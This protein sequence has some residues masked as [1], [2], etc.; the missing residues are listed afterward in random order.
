MRVTA[1]IAAV[2]ALVA[3]ACTDP[4]E[5]AGTSESSTTPGTGVGL[6]CWSAEPQDG[7][8]GIRFSDVTETAGLIEPLLGMKGHAAA[9]GDVNG[10]LILDLVV[11]TF[12]NARGDVYLERG[13]TGPAPDRLLLGDGGSFSVD[14][15][16]P[17]GIGRTSGAVIV[18]LDND[19][20]DDLVLSRNVVDDQPGDATTVFEQTPDGWV[21]VDA[22]IDPA[23]AGR[24][25]GVLDADGDG[26]LDLLIVVDRYRDG[27]SRIYRNIGGLEFQDMTEDWGLG[28]GV[29]GLG[30][31]TGDV[32]G[33]RLTDVFIAGSNR[34]FIGTGHGLEEVD[35]GIGPWETIGAE[36]DVAGAAMADVNRDGRLDLVVGQHYNSTVDR[37]SLVPVR[38][39]LNQTEP[40]SDPVFVDVTEEAG[41]VGLPTKAPHVELVDFD[42]DGW[43]DLLTTASAGDGTG[44]AVFRNTGEPGEIPVFETPEGLGDPQYWVTG[45]A[46]DFDRDGRVDL[47]LVEWEPSLPSLLLHNDSASGH[48]IEVSVGPE[49][50]GG[51]GTLVEAYQPGGADD[52]ERLIGAREITASLGYSA[53]VGRVAHFGLGAEESVDLVIT[54]P[55]PA[56]PLVLRGVPADQHVRVPSGCG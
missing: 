21:A 18:D 29:D 19:G 22:G 13:A 50:G 41:L 48:W 38:L 12:S 43:L 6:S 54:P 45:P 39:Y 2:L 26:L 9:W 11:G 36:D 4:P 53:G 3:V 15:A 52:P 49:L 56:D 24:S 32:N 8:P 23:M 10:D 44:P 35:A 46:G 27:D 25:I 34:F 1:A 17:E 14:A 47:F 42:N 55:F 7:E 20:D 16:F 31:A 30:V 5:P 37:G 40:G 33:D 51:V 28:H